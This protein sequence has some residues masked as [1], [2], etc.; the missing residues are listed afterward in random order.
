M[1]YQPTNQNIQLSAEQATNQFNSNKRWNMNAVKEWLKRSVVVAGLIFGLGVATVYA[2]EPEPIYLNP[3]GTYAEQ[4]QPEPL[5]IGGERGPVIEETASGAFPKFYMSSPGNGNVQG[6]GYAD[7]DIMLYNSGPGTWSKAFD[8]SDKGLAGSADIDAVAVILNSGYLS[9]LMSFEA[10]AAVPGLG[11]VDDSDVVRFDTWNN[12]WSMYLRGSTVG[13][14]TDGEDI[15][16]LT[17]SSGNSLVVSTRSSYTVKN[18]E[19]GNLSGNNR[20]LILLV[21]KNA[22]TWTKWMTGNQ[23][24]MTS[25]NNLTSASFVRYNESIIKDGRYLVGQ[26]GW[27]LPNGTVIGANDV[28]EQIWYQNGSSAWFKRLDNS[29]IGFAK[30]DALEVVK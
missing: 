6:W 1:N 24:G 7:E 20:D 17:F 12:Q 26:S 9:F 13:L 19:G 2:D 29:A 22:G 8:G 10:P 11:T 30:I 23:A 14:T 16:S 4:V 28:A 25:S 18:F 5:P 3:D 15:D 21:D 27:T